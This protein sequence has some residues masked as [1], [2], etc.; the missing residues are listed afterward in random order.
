MRTFST[1][2]FLYGVYR[3][4]VEEVLTQFLLYYSFSFEINKS[5]RHRLI[6]VIGLSM[7]SYTS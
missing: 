5:H 4:Q 1:R 3:I 2:I 6:E 7:E